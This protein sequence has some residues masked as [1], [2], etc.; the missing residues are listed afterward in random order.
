MAATEITAAMEG[1]P[2]KAMYGE[3][4]RPPLML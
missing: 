2:Y 3:P 1:T 4:L